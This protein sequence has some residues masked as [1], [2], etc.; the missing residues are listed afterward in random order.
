MRLKAWV[1]LVLAAST[2]VCAGAFAQ[3]PVPASEE[4]AATAEAAQGDAAPATGA[5]PLGE[6]AVAD[7][8]VTDATPALQLSGGAVAATLRGY[9]T[10]DLRKPLLVSDDIGALNYVEGSS[11]STGAKVF[12]YMA[13][14]S[15]INK[16]AY[17]FEP[18]G[19]RM[20]AEALRAGREFNAQIVAALPA[21]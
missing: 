7:G 4:P 16:A 20:H 9:L 15:T 8:P 13:G 21:Q 12:R 2:T 1:C 3:D 10:L 19:D 5:E 14:M 6:P 18:E 11:P 17:T